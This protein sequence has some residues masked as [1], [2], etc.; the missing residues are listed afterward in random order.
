MTNKPNPKLFQ[1]Y[2][3]SGDKNSIDSEVEKLLS[4]LKIPFSTSSPDTTIISPEKKSITIA[5]IRD[6]KSQ[7]YQKPVKEHYRL[8]IFDYADNITLEA[9]NALLKIFEEPPSHAILILKA[10]NIKNLIPTIVS[11][12]VVINATH[13]RQDPQE[14]SLLNSQELL[15]QVSQINSPENWINNQIEI[16]YNHLKQSLKLSQPTNKYIKIIEKL[17]DTK[18]M[19]RQNVN[20]KFVLFDLAMFIG[21]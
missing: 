3:L 6:L 12:A 21:N 10:Q 8:I 18:K 15:K 16:Y 13:K 11:R 7:I 2:L 19:I 20:P 5:Q 4:S 17:R 14:T 1:S 9:Q